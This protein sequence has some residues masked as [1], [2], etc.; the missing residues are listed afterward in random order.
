MRDTITAIAAAIVII[1]A[2]VFIWFMPPAAKQHWVQVEVCPGGSNYCN[3]RWTT[4]PVR[5]K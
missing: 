5:R 4:A 1:I 3:V 2:I